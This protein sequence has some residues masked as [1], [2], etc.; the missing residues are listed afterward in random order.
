MVHPQCIRDLVKS[1]FES[2]S[3]ADKIWKALNY[4]VPLKTIERWLRLLVTQ[5]PFELKRTR[6][7][8][9]A[10]RTK[11]LIAK[12]KRNLKKRAG[13]KSPQQ[14][15][16]ECG[17]DRSTIRRIISEDLSLKCYVIELSPALKEDHEAK[18][19]AAAAWIR[20][21]FNKKRVKKIMCT[22]EKM[23]DSDGK[24]NRHNDVVYAESREEATEIAGYHTTEKWPLKVMVWVG[25]TWNGPTEVVVLPKGQTFDSDFYVANVIP[26][27]KRCGERLVGKGLILQQDGA[28]PHTSRQSTEALQEEGIDF[29]PEKHWP[30]NSPDLNPVDYFFWNEVEERMPKRKFTSRDDLIKEIKKA[31][32]SVPLKMIR[33]A[34]KKF[35][36]R[37]RVV[38]KN[39]GKYVTQ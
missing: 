37:F 32:K 24:F 36:P 12:V 27:I 9:R 34:L 1:H 15:A 16:D 20:K 6:R 3:N 8:R 35:V 5:K 2:G 13:R 19:K 14:L 28:N 22:D 33:D 39:N 10:V 29:I 23:F 38:E 11:A 21:H 25:I 30:P 7:R 31:V 26:V 18:R 17:C 4:T